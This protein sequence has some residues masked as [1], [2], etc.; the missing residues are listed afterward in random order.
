MIFIKIET[1]NGRLLIRL[2][3]NLKPKIEYEPNLNHIHDLIKGITNVPNPPINLRQ[4][5]ESFGDRLL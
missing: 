2:T 3:H 1:Q 5:P 4:D